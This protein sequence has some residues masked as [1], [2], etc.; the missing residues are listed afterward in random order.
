MLF[1]ALAVLF[2]WV[3]CRFDKTTMHIGFDCYADPFEDKPFASNLMALQ[4]LDSNASG[5]EPKNA[6][7]QLT[8]LPDEIRELIKL[9]TYIGSQ[10]ANHPVN[11]HG[12]NLVLYSWHH[13]LVLAQITPIAT[14]PDDG[15]NIPNQETFNVLATWSFKGKAVKIEDLTVILVMGRDE[16]FLL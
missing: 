6:S 13:T 14:N 7:H 11:Q 2:A 5:E 12:A 10:V 9:D 8:S 3:V 4:R 15:T 1:L 16:V